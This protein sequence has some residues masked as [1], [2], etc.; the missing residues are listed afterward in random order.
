V[1]CAGG[2]E[3]APANQR[4]ASVL[5]RVH[6]RTDDLGLNSGTSSLHSKATWPDLSPA[7]RV[8]QPVSTTKRRACQLSWEED[9]GSSSVVLWFIVRFPLLRVLLFHC[10]E[11]ERRFSLT[12]PAAAASQPERLTLPRRIFCSEVPYWTGLLVR[13]SLIIVDLRLLQALSSVNHRTP[14]LSI[15]APLCNHLAER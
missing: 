6:P 5:A 8:C 14:L 1:W 9:L 4:R 15:D 12:R 3:E 7:G 11:H 2:S 10:A 13:P